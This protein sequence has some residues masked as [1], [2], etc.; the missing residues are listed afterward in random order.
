MK[1]STSPRPAAGVF[2]PLPATPAEPPAVIQIGR[3]SIKEG[4]SPAHRKVETDWARAFRRAQFPYHYLALETMT[5]V[6][7]VCVISPYPS[8]A[9]IEAGDKLFETGPSR[10]ELKVLESRSA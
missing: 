10:T 6:N 3:E 8:S 9:A 7:E 2:F 4:R 5:G 1:I